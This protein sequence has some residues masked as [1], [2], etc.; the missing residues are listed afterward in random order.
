MSWSDHYR[1]YAR[2]NRWM[3]QQLLTAC[4]SLTDDELSEPCG[5]FFDSLLG[6]WN[7]LLV[8]DII[9]LKRLAVIFPIL[10]EELK[11]L[12]MP[13][14][15]N[16]PLVSSQEALRPLRERLDDIC[17]RW[18]DLLRADDGRDMLT[19]TNTRGEEMVRPVYLVMQHIFNHQTHH[20]GQITAGL[21]R[22][23]IDYG[24]T[25]LLFAP[26]LEGF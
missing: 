9:W 16:Q 13:Q 12:P 21:S 25:D 6:T 2:Y 14:A 8:A 26:D 19:Y 7:H 23:N 22:R 3:N 10:E 1:R 5:L 20:R 17:I 18:C 4:S 15:V 11:D 24:E